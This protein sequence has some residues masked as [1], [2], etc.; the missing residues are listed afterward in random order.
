MH[1]FDPGDYDLHGDYDIDDVVPTI[2]R[3]KSVRF[4]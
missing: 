2:N 1:K 3:E 4:D